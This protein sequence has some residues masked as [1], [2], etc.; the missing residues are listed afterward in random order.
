MN[1]FCVQQIKKYRGRASAISFADGLSAT[2]IVQQVMVG[3]L[4][5]TPAAEV[6]ED[7][8]CCPR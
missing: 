4:G 6:G 7:E 3:E 8:E 1:S 5:Q 2:L